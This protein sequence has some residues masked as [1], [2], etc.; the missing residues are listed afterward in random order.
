MSPGKLTLLLIV[1]AIALSVQ[2]VIV[3]GMCTDK[4]K[5][6]ILQHCEDYLKHG[7]PIPSLHGPCCAAALEVPVLDMQ[8]IV[9]LLTAKEKSEYKEANILQLKHLCYPLSSEP[10]TNQVMHGLKGSAAMHH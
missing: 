1:F 5:K 10:P 7:A 3:N 2:P 9:D 6:D 4:E 8:C